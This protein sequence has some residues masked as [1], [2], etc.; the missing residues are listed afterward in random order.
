MRSLGAMTIMP[1]TDTN[2][3]TRIT[4][5]A[6]CRLAAGKTEGDLLAASERFQR[7]FAAGQPGILRRELVRKGEGEYLDIVQFRSRADLEEVL[8][9]EQE[10][11]VCHDFFAVMESGD[12]SDVAMLS[13]LQ[14][15]G[16]GD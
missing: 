9:L 6:P 7:E 13:S 5:L 11:T 12:E 1:N 16:P 8:A 10:S 15:F 3:G 14:T 4:V 2:N